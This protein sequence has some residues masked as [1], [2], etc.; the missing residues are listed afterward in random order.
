MKNTNKCIMIILLA[1]PSILVIINIWS[2][3][4][5]RMRSIVALLLYL[6]F[7]IYTISYKKH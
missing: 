1:I 7:F 2:K 5:S 6:V 3:N 4:N